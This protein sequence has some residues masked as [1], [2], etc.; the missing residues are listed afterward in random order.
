MGLELEIAQQIAIG[1]GGW[2]D[3]ESAEGLGPTFQ[4]HLPRSA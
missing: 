1:H 2:I 4:L 3:V